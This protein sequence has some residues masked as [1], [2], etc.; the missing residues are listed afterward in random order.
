[1]QRKVEVVAYNPGWDEQ[2]RNEM[3][4]LRAILGEQIVAIHHV[5][6]TA[7]PGVHAKPIIDVLVEVSQIAAIDAYNDE[8]IRQ[9]YIP[10]GEYGIAGRRY[11]IKGN[12][13]HRSHHIHI[14][15]VE[16]PEI[17]RHL[18]FRDYLVSHAADAKAYSDLKRELAR[19]FPTDINAYI[20]GKDVFIKE[21]DRKAAAWRKRG[22][23]E[24]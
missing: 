2:Y 23:Q 3:V 24:G 7:I 8:M 20:E 9:G 10:R 11:F 6:S 5:G 21:I 16:N 18:D 15:Q 4:A 13:I 12:E 22:G 14:F 19:R 17:Q 1:M